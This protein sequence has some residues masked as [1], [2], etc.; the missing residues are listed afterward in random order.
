MFMHTYSCICIYILHVHVYIVHVYAYYSSCSF[1]FLVFLVHAGNVR[2]VPCKLAHTENY[3]DNARLSLSCK[4]TIK[5]KKV[6]WSPILMVIW[7]IK[8]GRSDY[9]FPSSNLYNVPLSISE[10][11]YANTHKFMFEFIFSIFVRQTKTCALNNMEG[12]IVI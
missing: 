12:R 8:W 4:F 10:R 5:A 2:V 6:I 1:I 7:S 3:V 11:C 9:F